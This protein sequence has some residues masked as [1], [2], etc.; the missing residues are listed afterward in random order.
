MTCKLE[1]LVI[2][3]KTDIELLKENVLEVKESSDKVRKSLFA[4][5]SDLLRKYTE[6]SERLQIIERNI[7]QGAIS[8]SLQS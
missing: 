6:L 3:E 1:Y 5:H 2:E 8:T 7:C 4:R